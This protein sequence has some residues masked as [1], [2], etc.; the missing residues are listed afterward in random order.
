ME[1]LNSDVR[2]SQSEA[3]SRTGFLDTSFSPAL[4][5]E[6]LR[7]ISSF[8]FDRRSATEKSYLFELSHFFKFLSDSGRLKSIRDVTL[9]D[10]LDYQGCISN[11]SKF[12]RARAMAILKSFF[13]F[14]QRLGYIDSTPTR[15][16]AIGRPDSGISD[17]IIT[18]EEVF[19]MIEGKM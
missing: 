14:A 8:L 10:I 9:R 1:T 19:L 11:K 15:F 18:R 12:T 16:C 3:R 4:S 7:L 5:P 17:R 2:D 13:K 6:D